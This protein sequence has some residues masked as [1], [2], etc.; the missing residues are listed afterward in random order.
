M[1]SYIAEPLGLYGYKEQEPVI[2]AA[3]AN[4]GPLL[5]L[6]KHGLGKSMLIERIASAL[7][8]ESRLYNASLINYDDLVGMPYP[9][10]NKTALKYI[11]DDSAI[12]DAEFVF[13]DEINR[14][15]P[16]LQ[17]KLFPIINE[18]RVQGKSL[19]KLRYRWSAMNPPFASNDEEDEEDEF[20]Y[21]GTSRLDEALADRFFYF[22]ESPEFKDL[23][24]EEKN[25]AIL[26]KVASSLPFSLSDL[27]E[28]TKE[29]VKRIP[30][31][32]KDYLLQLTK[33]ATS[34]LIESVGNLSI[35]RSRMLY[36]SALHIHAARMTLQSKENAKITAKPQDSFLIALDN[37]LPYKVNH[38]INKGQIFSIFTITIELV[39]SDDVM[40]K[41][42]KLPSNEERLKFA[43]VHRD[44][45]SGTDF[46]KIIPTGINACGDKKG[47][48]IALI[49]YLALKDRTDIPAVVM[50]KI[51]NVAYPAMKPVVE[52]YM[53]D[54]NSS[55]LKISYNEAVEKYSGNLKLQLEN[56]LN[57]FLPEG[58]ENPYEIASLAAYFS[59]LEQEVFNAQK[60]KKSPH[61]KTSYT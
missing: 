1:K 46:S 28:E 16:E 15:K 5:I 27:I 35:R 59:E 49:S 57:S 32:E 12:W 34:L 61:W 56:L 22:L 43:L 25:S 40:S 26:G 14:T 13:I 54:D 39:G 37:C 7:N 4:E 23:S 41:I 36:E 55:Q 2:L 42:Y 48:A 45:F 11:Y 30:Q 29:N 38:E 53:L 10:E 51:V 18:K 24:N 44:E 21:S 19:T 6:G 20:I 58:Y 9:N 3:L 8:I 17:N 60:Q 50:K 31:S 47:R 52:F 33:Q